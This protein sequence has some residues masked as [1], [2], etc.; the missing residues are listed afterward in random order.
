MPTV[1]IYQIEG[2]TKEQKRRVVEGIT[3]LISKEYG[4]DK[5][6]VTVVFHEKSKD[7]WARGGKLFS[8]RKT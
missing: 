1:F 4:V 2:R 8:E 6:T 7:D 3:E 5:E